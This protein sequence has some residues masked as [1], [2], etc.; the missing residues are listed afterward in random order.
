MSPK[1][2]KKLDAEALL[3]EEVAR[4]YN[5]PLGFVLAMF[6]WGEEGT[7]LAKHDG[8]DKWQRD[9]LEYI[10]EQVKLRAFDG[11]NAVK[12][13]RVAVSAGH[14]VG[15]STKDA[16]MSLWL[17][18]TRPMC[19]G[20]V[21]A[22]SFPQLETKTWAAIRHWT[23]LCYTGHWFKVTGNRMYHLAYPESWFCAA[24]SSKEENSE[25]FA[26][27]HALD[28]SSFYLFDEAS[29]IPEVIFAVAEGGLTDGEPFILLDGNP[30]RNTGYFYN[31]CFG[32]MRDRW[33]VFTVDSRESKLTNKE[34][35]A[36]WIEDHG[37]DSDF[38]RVRVRGL[39]PRASDLQFISQTLVWEAQKRE[40]VILP[41]E[42][43]I[44]GVDVS[45]GGKA[46]NVI[47]FR[48]G[49]DARNIPPVRIPGEVTR[50]DRTALI[51]KLAEIL[52]DEHRG[53]RVSMMFFDSA[54]GAPYVERLRTM[55]FHNVQEVRFGGSSPDT[56]SANMRAYMWGAM[57]EWL[58][59]GAIDQNDARLEVDLTSPGFKVTSRDRI[60]IESKE[61]MS[62]RGVDSPDDGDALALTF[63]SRV[64]VRR[65]RT[66]MPDA[67]AGWSWS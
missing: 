22:N 32:G 27:Q 56:R 37:E 18:S 40:I 24:Q 5:D 49:M 29:A 12:P 64:S 63:A 54:F 15:K 60:L 7:A 46:W 20:T 28:S 11:I 44:A 45:D 67:L 38:V 26:G 34:Q 41:T 59:W 53:E 33:K 47:R 21:T 55:G 50:D 9:Y 51:A 4:Y 19:K 58:A 39:P 14:G 31:V 17:M 6:P 57:R 25:S 8:P 43:L 2:A 10:G 35:I 1:A 61:D 13:I 23:T 48:R 42:P 36:E 65:T 66:Y 16:W 30:T 3:A 52:T 62:K